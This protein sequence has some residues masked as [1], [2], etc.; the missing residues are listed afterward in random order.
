MFSH[1]FIE[2]LHVFFYELLIYIQQRIFYSDS[3][4]LEF[5]S[6]RFFIIIIQTSSR[7]HFLKTKGMNYLNY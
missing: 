7:K 1:M 6:L 4:L 3:E 5:S 2:H